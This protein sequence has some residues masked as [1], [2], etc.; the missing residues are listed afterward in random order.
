[1]WSVIKFH[2]NKENILKLNLM[3]KFGNE[4]QFYSPKILIQKK[5]KNLYRK[6]EKNILGDYIF[7][8][9]KKFNEKNYSDIVKF[10][11]GLKELLNNCCYSQKEIN[12]F[13][14]FCKKYE[15]NNGYLKSTFFQLIENKE[16]KFMSGPFSD[17]IFTILEKNKNRINILLGNIKTSI[18]KKNFL[19]SPII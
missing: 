17:K 6:I 11:K 16:Y 3:K 1:M 5:R 15:N 8:F 9:H 2:K 19:Y 12:E 7:C 4:I 14:K 10:T 18:D 13:I